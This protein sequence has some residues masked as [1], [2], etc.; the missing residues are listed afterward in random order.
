[1]ADEILD[2]IW[3]VRAEL[4]KKH[5]GIHGYMEYVRKLDLA[6]RKAKSKRKKARAGKLKTS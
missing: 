6:R 4:V 5:G 2:E 1:M 3:R